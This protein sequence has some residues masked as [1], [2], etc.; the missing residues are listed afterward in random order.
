LYGVAFAVNAIYFL[1]KQSLE[2]GL[3]AFIFGIPAIVIGGAVIYAIF[4]NMG[5]DEK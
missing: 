5:N 1:H 4:N 3:V 2:H